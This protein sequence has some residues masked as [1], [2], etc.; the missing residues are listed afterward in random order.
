MTL[1]HDGHPLVKGK[2]EEIPHFPGMPHRSVVGGD[3]EAHLE[4]GA[5]VRGQ[6]PLEPEEGEHPAD[7]HLLLEDLQGIA[8]VT[9]SN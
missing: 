9:L 7:A 4:E 6:A 3:H 2:E 5:G 8:E 1:A